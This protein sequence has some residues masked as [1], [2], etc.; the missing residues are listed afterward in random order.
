MN[1]LLISHSINV[2]VLISV[3]ASFKRMKDLTT[4]TETIVEALKTSGK[5][6]ISEDGQ[7]IRRT[8]PLPSEDPTLPRSIYAVSD[9]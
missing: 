6:E 2:D 4:D 7:K 8:E 1:N 5:L 9:L 3:I